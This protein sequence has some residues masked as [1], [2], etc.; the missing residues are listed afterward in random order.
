MNQYGQST[1]SETATNV[2]ALSAGAWHSLAFRSDGSVI[3]FGDNE[4]LAATDFFT[5]E[6]WTCFGLITYYV[7]LFVRLHSREVHFAG[8][9]QHPT[10]AW[11]GQ[12]AWNVTMAEV[13]FLRGCRYVLHDRDPKFTR[14]FDQI[15][16]AA[17]VEPV[18]LP[19]RSPNLNASCE[20]WIRSATRSVYRG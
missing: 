15:L 17:G 4:V 7:L 11:M 6:V 1:V 3:A 14:G 2:V 8:V 18:R 12:V 9:T 5:A 19:V 16:S 13:G 20:R 10:E